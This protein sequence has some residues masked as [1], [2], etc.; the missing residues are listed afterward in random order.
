MNQALELKSNPDVARVI[1]VANPS[2]KKRQAF[3]SAFSGHGVS[4]NSYWDSGSRD[5]FAVVE[6]ATMTLRPLPTRAHPFFEVAAR[7]LASTENETVA[8]DHVGNITL[9]VLPE[10]FALVRTGVFCGKPGTAHVYLNPANFAKLL[11]AAGASH[12]A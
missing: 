5:Y 1:R 3:V 7:G 10:G 8:V 9:K 11:P 12:A 4:I 2:Y 6:L